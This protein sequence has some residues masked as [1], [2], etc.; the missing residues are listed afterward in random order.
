MVNTSLNK[1][2]YKIFLQFIKI[3]PNVLALF[4]IISLILNYMRI[5]PFALT[6]ISG[7]SLIFLLLLYLISYVFQFCGTHRVSL[8]YVTTITLVTIIDFYIGIPVKVDT[9]YRLYAIITGVFMITWII[10]WYINKDN[11]TIDHAKQF[12]EKYVICC[13]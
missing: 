11:P 4:K 10:V 6:C 9:L 1:N 13:K 8:N 2:L 7:T 5:Y 3:I 12:C